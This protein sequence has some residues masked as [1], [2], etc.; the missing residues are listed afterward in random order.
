[1]HCISTEI[2]RIVLVRLNPRED[3]LAGLREAV[4]RE[5]ITNALILN[6]VGSVSSFHYHVVADTNLPPAEA[7]P[8]AR[9][10]RDIVAVS[11]LIMDGRVHA[12]ITLSDDTRAEGGHLEEGT[13]VLTFSVIAIGDLGDTNLSG[14]DHVGPL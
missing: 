1:M 3:I 12:H 6:G 10:P 14:W 2:T 4:E 8:R 5:S 13:R 9:E 7:F 11:G